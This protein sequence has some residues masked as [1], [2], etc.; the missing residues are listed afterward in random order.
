M[1]SNKKNNNHYKNNGKKVLNENYPRTF[2]RSIGIK[3]YVKPN[4][5]IGLHHFKKAILN[6]L[7]K[8]TLKLFQDALDAPDSGKTFDLC[9]TKLGFVKIWYGVDF[10]RTCLIANILQK[11]D[12]P[13]NKNILDIGGGPGHMAFLM[14]KL[15]PESNITVLD[16]YSHIGKE[17]AS[18][19]NEGRVDFK[20]G[21]LSDLKEIEGCKYDLITMSRVIGNLEHLSLPTYP[22]TFDSS[23]YLQSQEGKNILEGFEEIGTV[24]NEH[25]TKSG[26]LVIIDSWSSIRALLI[27][28]AFEK[29]GLYIDIEHFNPEELSTKYSMIIFSKSKPIQSYQDLPLGLATFIKEDNGDFLNYFSDQMAESFRE[30]F[31][32]SRVIF[33]STFSINGLDTSFKQEVMEKNGIAIRYISTTEGVRNAII[34]SSLHIPF[35]IQSCEKEEKVLKSHL[36]AKMLK[37]QKLAV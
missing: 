25:L 21:Q 13:K 9:H 22:G 36:T 34:G 10:Y 30:L 4:E 32:G 12:L 15:W 24:I 5:E 27:A 2:F 23:S 16:K 8:E 14:S 3:P 6:E 17:W 26:H 37:N 19:I 29:K 1:K 33:E 11:I 31:A 7:G 35:F 20:N 28:K 18:E